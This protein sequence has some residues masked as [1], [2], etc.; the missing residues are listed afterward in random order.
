MF[1]SLMVLLYYI[2]SDLNK[3]NKYL[4]DWNI[5]CEYLI[6]YETQLAWTD[7]ITFD[8]RIGMYTF[9]NA[10]S[11][12]LPFSAHFGPFSLLVNDSEIA[13]ACRHIMEKMNPE[14]YKNEI[15]KIRS[16]DR[17][18]FRMFKRFGNLAYYNSCVTLH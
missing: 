16:G 12:L 3:F 11:Y 14:K 4:E 9:K 6:L 10:Y 15:S 2:E 8:Q 17:K 7:K 1:Y 18:N 13:F 5:H